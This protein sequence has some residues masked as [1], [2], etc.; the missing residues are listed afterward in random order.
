[1]SA[2]LISL[3]SCIFVGIA[4]IPLAFV[5]SYDYHVDANCGSSARPISKK[6]GFFGH[7]DWLFLLTDMIL[8]HH[9]STFKKKLSENVSEHL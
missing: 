3:K 9:L 2:N 4:W 5:S 8:W 6:P 7:V 1:M